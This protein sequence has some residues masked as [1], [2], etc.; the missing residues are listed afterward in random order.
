MPIEFAWHAGMAKSQKQ[1]SIR[2]LHEAL[3]VH[4]PAAR[5]LEV[6]SASENPLG[7]RLS[8]FNLTFL[9]RGREREIPV[10]CAFQ[11]AKVF[12]NGGPFTELM[13]ARPVVAKR[14]PRLQ[15]SGRL[16]G[17]RF[18]GHDWALEP[19]T[20][21]YD[22]IYINALHLQAELAEA[23]MDYDTFTDIAF[24]PAK[25]VNCQA[26]SVA[27]YAS[28]RRRN[29]LQ[30]ALKSRDSY[31]SVIS[32]MNGKGVRSDDGPQGRLL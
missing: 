29:L 13:D 22:W 1:K 10:E 8:A 11:G 3:R 7:E 32:G 21:F 18:S 12:E 4:L 24:N 9:T 23:V 25:S 14:D 17:F 16:I 20:A 26:G 31:L 27:L 30:E 6:S 5:V 15:N 2:S 28:L 19:L